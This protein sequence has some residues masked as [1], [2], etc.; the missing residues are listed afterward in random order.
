MNQRFEESFATLGALLVL[1][2]VLLNPLVSASRAAAFL[3]VYAV[4]RRHAP[5][6][7]P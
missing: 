3:L 7:K 6:G 2:T 4:W 1:F 5:R